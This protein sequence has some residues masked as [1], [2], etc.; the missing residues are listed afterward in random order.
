MEGRSVDLADTID[1]CE[2]ILS[3]EFSYLNENDFFMVG[4][5]NEVLEKTKG[6]KEEY[7]R[8]KLEESA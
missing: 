6:K 4:S 7:E 3:G 2:R 1:G 5:L 8:L